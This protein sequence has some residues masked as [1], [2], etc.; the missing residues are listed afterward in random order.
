MPASSSCCCACKRYVCCLL[1]FIIYSI[2]L[3]C[4][5]MVSICCRSVTVC[6]SASLR[7][8]LYL[9]C[10]SSVNNVS[11]VPPTCASSRWHEASNYCNINSCCLF[12]VRRRYTS[13]P[14]ALSALVSVCTYFNC[15]SCLRRR[16]ASAALTRSLELYKLR[17]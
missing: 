2:E 6:P 16:C 5:R 4:R 13:R 9:I 15:I 3:R 1:C 12:S 17:S 10:C 7:S 11:S 14:R 8:N